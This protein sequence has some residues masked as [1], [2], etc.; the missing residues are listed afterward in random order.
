MS[1]V[2]AQLPPGSISVAARNLRTGATFTY[3]SS[4]DQ[5]EA[6]VAKLDIIETLMLQHQAS[7]EPLS[8]EESYQATVMIEESDNDAA[9]DLYEDVGLV[10]GVEAANRTL[11]LKC[12]VPSAHWG[13][14]V[15]CAE[16]QIRLLDQ[17]ESASSP[18]TPAS[19]AYVLN[20]MQNVNATQQWGVPVVADPGTAFSVKDGWLNVEGDTDWVVNSEGIVRCNGQTLLITTLTQNNPTMASGM[21]LDEQLARMAAAAVTAQ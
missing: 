3:G 10:S 9:T 19:R 21:A 16:D 14:T 8:D 4:G 12:T 5:T 11:G 13:L 18:L 17:L 7:A 2:A 15:T 20:L 1:K 6:S